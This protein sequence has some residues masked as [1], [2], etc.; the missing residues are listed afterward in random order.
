MSTQVLKCYNPFVPQQTDLG[1][2][3]YQ[4]VHCCPQFCF[5]CMLVLCSKLESA[6]KVDYKLSKRPPGALSFYFAHV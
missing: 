2:I 6:D 4:V 5:H 1:D 3:E